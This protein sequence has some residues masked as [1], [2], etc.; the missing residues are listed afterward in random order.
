MDTSEST[1]GR[2]EEEA[3]L[4][5]ERGMQI[6]H[7][8]TEQLE[9]QIRERPGVTLLAALGLGYLIGRIVRR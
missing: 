5:R 9:M 3:E 8:L 6:V 1:Q 4:L 7:R 2:L